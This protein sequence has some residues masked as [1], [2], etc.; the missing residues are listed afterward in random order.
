[1][2][3]EIHPSDIDIFEESHLFLTNKIN[4]DKKKMI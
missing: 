1:M 3:Q 2:T 4:D